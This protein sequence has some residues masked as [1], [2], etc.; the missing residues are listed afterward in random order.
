M[1][2]EINSV[3]RFEV[4]GDKLTL[5]RLRN[6]PNPLRPTTQDVFTGQIGTLRFTRD[7]NHRISGVVLD[8]G[9]IQGF[10]FT[11]RGTL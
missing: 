2:E 6:K 5:L 9:R 4:R 3:Y 7:A 11:R 10:Q 1:S 8:A